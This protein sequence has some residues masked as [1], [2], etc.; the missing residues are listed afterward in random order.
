MLRPITKPITAGRI[1]PKFREK[2]GNIFGASA[3][4]PSKWSAFRNAAGS[5]FRRSTREAVQVNAVTLI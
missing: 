3:R 5:V 4:I 2:R 1:H